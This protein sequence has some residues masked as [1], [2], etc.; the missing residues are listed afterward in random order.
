CPAGVFA[1]RQPFPHGQRPLVRPYWLLCGCPESFAI[2]PLQCHTVVT[3]HEAGPGAISS[4]RPENG[5]ALAEQG[6]NLGELHPRPDQPNQL[7]ALL[8]GRQVRGADLE[9]FQQEFSEL[10]VVSEPRFDLFG[11]WT[12]RPSNARASPES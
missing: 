2:V 5:L 9:G 12:S 6:V 7:P 11:L 10:R 1:R 4:I 3:V 8:V